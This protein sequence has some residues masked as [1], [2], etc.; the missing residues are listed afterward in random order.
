MTT[1]QTQSVVDLVGDR[2]D[3]FVM[4][5]QPGSE[6]ETVISIDRGVWEDM[7]SPEKLTVTVNPGDL[8]NR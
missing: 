5:G 6:R 1:L 7:G 8:L 3:T 2:F 4:F